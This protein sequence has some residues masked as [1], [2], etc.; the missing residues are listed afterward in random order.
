VKI[1]VQTPHQ[2]VPAPTTVR[3]A[4]RP[5]VLAALVFGAATACYVATLA[6]TVTFVDSGELIAAAKSLSVAHAPGFPLYIVVA[7]VSTWLPFGTVAERVHL[8]SAVFA[9]VAAA[10]VALLALEILRRQTPSRGREQAVWAGASAALSGGLLFAFSRTLWSYATEAEV[11]SLNIALVLAVALLV[12]RWSR[13]AD[14]GVLYAAAALFGVA[15][16]VHHVTVA[17]TLPA[18][19][20][21]LFRAR[22]ARFLASKTVLAAALVALGAAVLVYAYLPLAASRRVGL[23][24]GDPQT[25][26]RLWWHV[27][28]RQYQTY[29]D[30]SPGELLHRFAEK[31]RFLLRQ[32]GP[33][34]LPLAYVAAAGGA[35]RLFLRDRTTF[36]FLVLLL[37]PNLGYAPFYAIS[38][39]KDAYLLPTYAA[40]AVA[41]AVGVDALREVRALPRRVAVAGAVGAL[42]LLPA[43]SLASSLP[44]ENRHHYFAA[45]D[46]VD[47][48]LSTI[49][50]NGFLLTYDWEVYSPLLYVR[51]V[52]RRRLDVVAIDGN[53]L[54]RSWYF[55]YL[56]RTYPELL[57]AVRAPVALYLEDLRRWE[58]D[59]ALYERPALNRRIEARFQAVIASLIR[60]ASKAGPVYAT[61]DIA[62]QG[63]TAAL[64][65]QHFSFVPQGLVLQLFR[66]SRFH[67]P[68]SPPL[69][70]RGLTDGAVR[71]ERDDVVREEV[72]RPVLRML[73]LRGLYF[74][75]FDRPEQARKAFQEADRF[76]SRFGL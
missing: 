67:Q 17:L 22:G 50:P 15:L 70:L 60:V 53:L 25:F 26:E 2:R 40:L 45:R 30:L 76:R 57:D 36:W 75:A 52:E 64:L 39:D 7:H 18:L 44:F 61:Q 63:D 24:W 48:M 62:V 23:N 56:K 8:A 41:A 3:A 20:W 14:N 59:H 32:F 69:R 46:Y 9:A 34:W 4:A 5:Y 55:D 66:D 29:F 12:L 73:T 74:E 10:V 1:E 11:Y 51:E 16:G 47:G 54:R 38:E 37:V 28:G 68:A 21:L 27:S 6:P 43:V 72:L 19:V 31:G 35:V 49:G 13:G 33:P 42:A 58:R 65:A 71:L